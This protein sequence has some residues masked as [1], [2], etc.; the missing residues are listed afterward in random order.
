[1]V[2]Y[3]YKPPSDDEEE[4]E[5]DGGAD[6]AEVED[7][8]ANVKNENEDEEKDEGGDDDGDGEDEEDDDDEEL[9]AEMIKL[10]LLVAKYK[11]K[12]TE[13]YSAATAAEAKLAKYTEQLRNF[14]QKPVTPVKKPGSASKTGA[15]AS[16]PSSAYDRM[17][18]DIEQIR[19]SA[20]KKRS[21]GSADDTTP[22]GKRGGNTAES[23]LSKK[24]K[25]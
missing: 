4:E 13:A 25:K 11:Q 1:M 2:K 5:E 22:K 12:A 6:D 18:A 9:D 16:T 20:S 8:G 10:Q 24:H 15:K 3:V 14:G 19:S 7:E 17:K 21:H 23:P